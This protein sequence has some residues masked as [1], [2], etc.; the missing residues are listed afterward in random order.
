M[1]EVKKKIE[2]KKRTYYFRTTWLILTI[3]SQT[4]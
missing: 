2:I 4:C 3:S 1:G